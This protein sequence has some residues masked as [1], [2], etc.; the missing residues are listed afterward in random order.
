LTAGEGAVDEPDPHVIQAARS[1]DLDAFG[2]L[3]RRYQGDVYRFVLHLIGDPT[4]AE[5]ITQDSFVRAYRF[6]GRY[7]GDSRFSTWLFSI[8]RNCVNDE[9][10]RAGRRARL[11][12]ALEA[13][14]P[15]DARSD[16]TSEIE[17]REALA[18]LPHDLLESVV[19][20]DIFGMS[21]REASTLTGAPEGTLKSRV[22]RAR[23]RLVALLGPHPEEQA[24]E[25]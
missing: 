6:L 13:H 22:H 7:R 15:P 2:S 8:A 19:I 3:V 21:Y 18:S 14:E 5:D 11:N 4:S 23:E 10:R 9:L 25:G 16:R 12:L 24:D 20:I 17:V 1:G